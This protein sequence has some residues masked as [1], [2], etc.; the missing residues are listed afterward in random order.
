MAPTPPTTNIFK[1]RSAIR[2]TGF[3]AGGA[4]AGDS[5]A[6]AFSS[7]TS[8]SFSLLITQQKECQQDIGRGVIVGGCPFFISIVFELQDPCTKSSL[9]RCHPSDAESLPSC[10]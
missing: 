7:A 4:L 3:C 8:D 9:G 5:G 1:T 6:F 2:S 10:F